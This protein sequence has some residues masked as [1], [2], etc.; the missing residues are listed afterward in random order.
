MTQSNLTPNISVIEAL[1]EAVG[2]LNFR[3][4]SWDLPTLLTNSL[5]KESYF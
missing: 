5:S 3:V 1:K 2:I 4:L